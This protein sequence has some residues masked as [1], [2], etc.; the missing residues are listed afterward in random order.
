M[1]PPPSSFVGRR[2]RMAEGAAGKWGSM[3]ILSESRGV[4]VACLIF[5]ALAPSLWANR[6]LRLVKVSI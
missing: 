4:L 6:F 1:R 3:A 2:H 5:G